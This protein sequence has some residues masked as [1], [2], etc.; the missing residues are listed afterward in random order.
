MAA[1]VPCPGQPAG[2]PGFRG[3]FLLLQSIES[4]S[5]RR[6]GS[7]VYCST[8]AI[9]QTQTSTC[10]VSSAQR[11]AG[12]R[13][14][15]SPKAKASSGRRKSGSTTNQERSTLPGLV[16]SSR[17]AWSASVVNF[18]SATGDRRMEE[19]LGRPPRQF[20]RRDGAC[21]ASA[22]EGRRPGQ[23]VSWPIPMAIPMGKRAHPSVSERR[24]GQELATGRRQ[25]HGK[26]RKEGN[27]GSPQLAAGS[28]VRACLVWVDPTAGRRAVVFSRNE[29]ES[30]PGP[31]PSV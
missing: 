18:E 30:S 21:A 1:A 9:E 31:R 15:P 23:P 5:R 12:L 28:G 26:T 11:V 17:K 4:G 29:P 13:P 2:S 3:D 27:T 8:T 22:V 7:G 10:H 16:M 14:F 20:R 19:P 24:W 25:F 6:S